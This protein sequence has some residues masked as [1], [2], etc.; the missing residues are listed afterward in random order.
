MPFWE[1]C[2][3]LKF[4]PESRVIAVTALPVDGPSWLFP[5]V[6]P[7]TVHIRWDLSKEGEVRT[8][9]DIPKDE[10]QPFFIG[11]QNCLL[12]NSIGHDKNSQKEEEEENV[13]HL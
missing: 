2:D 1:H 6:R 8:V 3:G 13:L 7:L 11:D 12:G 9:E 4:K 5:S 10:V